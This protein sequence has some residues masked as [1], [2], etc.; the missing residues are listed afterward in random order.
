MQSVERAWSAADVFVEDVVT[1]QPTTSYKVLVEN[2][3]L[4]GISGL[5][6]VDGQGKLWHRL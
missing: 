2:L 1:V 6:V 3:W 4:Q 5:P